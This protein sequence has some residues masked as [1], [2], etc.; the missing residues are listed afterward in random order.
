MVIWPASTAAL[1]QHCHP[2]DVFATN[3]RKLPCGA[4]KQRTQTALGLLGVQYSCIPHCTESP[5]GNF[6]E[7]CSVTTR[8][9]IFLWQITFITENAIYV[10][11][12]SLVMKIWRHQ[13]HHGSSVTDSFIVTEYKFSSR[14]SE[15]RWRSL[16]RHLRWVICDGPS[17]SPKIGKSVTVYH[18]RWRNM[19]SQKINGVMRIL[20]GGSRNADVA[21]GRS[22]QR[23][24]RGSWQM[25]LIRPFCITI[26]YHNLL[27]YIDIFHI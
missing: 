8:E 2:W 27:L 21:A 19:P 16:Q 23:C 24:W 9:K 10:T 14:K 11:Y 6:V 17:T 26:L 12:Y 13:G 1:Q 18:I 4:V 7:L 3:H 20:A 15:L 5:R 22:V 25:G